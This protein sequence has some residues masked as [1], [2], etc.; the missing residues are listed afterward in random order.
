MTLP[1]SSYQNGGILVAI[2]LIGEAA[3]Q[4]SVDEH[5]V[6]IGASSLAA[7]ADVDA[8]LSVV[9]IGLYSHRATHAYTTGC[10]MRDTIIWMHPSTQNRTEESGPIVY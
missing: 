10:T 1:V 3:G 9:T 2:S 6:A 5:L 8:Y 4:L 7:K